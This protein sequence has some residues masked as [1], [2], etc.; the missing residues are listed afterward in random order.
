MDGDARRPIDAGRADE[1][2]GSLD[3]ELQRSSTAQLKQRK[4]ELL[5]QTEFGTGSA[6]ATQAGGCAFARCCWEFASSLKVDPRLWNHVHDKCYCDECTAAWGLGVGGAEPEPEPAGADDGGIA[7]RGVSKAQRA[8]QCSGWMYFGL[9]MDDG[10]AAARGVW[11]QWDTAFHGTTSE[12]FEKIV[13]TGQLLIPGDVTP[14][15]DRLGV[16]DGH[17]SGGVL[18]PGR[19]DDRVMMLDGAAGLEIGLEAFEPCA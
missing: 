17:I 13:Q 5:G 1:S 8:Q 9:K 7:G 16:R 15:G 12:S 3:G 10:R 4:A 14:D 11:D 2:P 19:I 18:R 6:H